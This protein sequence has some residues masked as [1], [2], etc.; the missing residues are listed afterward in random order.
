[1]AFKVKTTKAAELQIETAY[2]WLKKRNPSY[3]DEWFK[4]L[5]NAIANSS[6]NN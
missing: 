6:L 5:M 3:A 1:M 4:G 2:L